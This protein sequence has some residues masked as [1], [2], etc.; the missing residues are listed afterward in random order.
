VIKKVEK[1]IVA[2]FTEGVRVIIPAPKK[3]VTPTVVKNVTPA[4]VVVVKKEVEKAP[5]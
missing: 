2:K 5:V 1:P 4:P 3:K